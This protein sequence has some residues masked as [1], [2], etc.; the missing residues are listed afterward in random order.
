MAN[1]SPAE[2]PAGQP[3]RRVLVVD[4]DPDINRLVQMRLTVRGYQVESAADGDEALA[5]IESF[6]P[7]V[8]FLDV[9]MPNVGGMEVLER[10]RAR[11]L[12]VAVIMTTAFGSEQVAIEALRRGADDYLRKPFEPRE[13]Q[14]VLDRTVGRLELRRQN[15]AL[16]SQLEEQH[17]QLE[18]ELRRA[19]QV[20][21]D[22]LPSEPPPLPGFELAARCV[23]AREVGGDFYD[24]LMPLPELF[25]FSL[26]DAMGKGMSAALLMATVRAALRALAAQNPPAAAMD[27]LARALQSDLTRSGGYMTLF[28]ARLNLESRRLYYVDGGHGYVL[29]RRNDG[30]REALKAGGLPL[31]LFPDQTYQ[32]GITSLA[33]GDTLVVFSDGLAEALPEVAADPLC[34]ADHLGE[35]PAAA[36]IVERLVQLA[37]IAGPPADDVTV[38]V[39]R[40]IAPPSRPGSAESRTGQGAARTW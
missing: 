31:G 4:D 28:H 18:A 32:S 13:F 15:A 11:G 24:W 2:A 6:Q 20:Q 8:V 40:C 25:S 38:L 17:R 1:P 34:L 23:P 35:G 7:D 3:V 22:L 37:T 26:G 9:S 16:R 33:P 19:A 14:A 10:V 29:L 30:R 27:L 5:R 21:A 12:D 36:D 39:L